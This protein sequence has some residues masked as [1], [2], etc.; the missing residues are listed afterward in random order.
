M[1]LY[2]Y[3]GLAC[4]VLS[5]AL[6]IM[7]LRNSV[8]SLESDIKDLTTENQGLRMQV[9]QSEKMIESLR[10]DYKVISDFNSELSKANSDLRIQ[11]QTLQTKLQKL[12]SG[13]SEMAKKHPKMLSN[14]INSAQKDTNKCF[15]ML[16]RGLECE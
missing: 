12:N 7:F 4:V 1:K 8:V 10:S 9:I 2:L 16:S 13:Y 5:V 11:Q 14:I 15:E 6:Y 3:L